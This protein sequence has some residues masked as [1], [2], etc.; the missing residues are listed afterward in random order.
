MGWSDPCVAHTG[1]SSCSASWS[2][3]AAP[4]L[5]ALYLRA[6]LEHRFTISDTDFQPPFGASQAPYEA[7]ILPLVDGTAGTRLPGAKLTAVR[8]DG[9]DS[10]LGQ[11][12][13]YAKAKGFFDRLIYYPV[14][15]PAT[16]G[17]WS[18]L[19]S[20]AQALH[21]VDP[22]GRIIITSTIQEADQNSATNAVDI[23]VPVINYLEDKAGSSYTGDQTGKYAAWLAGKASRRLWTYQSCMS[24]GCGSCGTPSTT[25]YWTGWPNRVIDSSAVQNRCLPWLAF[26]LGVSGELYFQT[27][28]QLAT[29]WDANGQCAFSGSGDGTLFYPGKPSVIGGTKDIPV[30]SIRIKLI[31]EGMEDYEYL[32]LAAAKDAAKADTVARGLFPH[33]YSCDQ[34]PAQ[35]EAARD[36]LF[37]LLDTTPATDG[38]PADVGPTSDG[39]RDGAADQGADDGG[40][41]EQGDGEPHGGLGGGCGCRLGA[42][43]APAPLLPLLFLL[44]LVGLARR[45]SVR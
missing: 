21:A 24:H 29:A 13:A 10:D 41:T 9:G 2:E 38:G 43:N 25:S 5:R 30:E 6:G 1:Y 26:W 8:I 4:P 32:V 40:A 22:Q 44:V 3:T 27:T 23:F 36:Q 18:T 12:V 33:T 16:S 19:V 28:H 31:R 17:A 15:E 7:N 35:L 42:R 14:D 11:W 34:T 39:S 20:G 37:A 45:V